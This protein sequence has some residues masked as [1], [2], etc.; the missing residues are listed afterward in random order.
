MKMAL[1]ADRPSNF[2][3]ISDVIQSGMGR[4]L[5]LSMLTG[6][7]VL[8]KSFQRDPSTVTRVSVNHLDSLVYRRNNDCQHN[9]SS[10]RTSDVLLKD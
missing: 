3:W 1:D 10:I 8:C 7:V 2:T 4:H 5:V 6:G 9:E